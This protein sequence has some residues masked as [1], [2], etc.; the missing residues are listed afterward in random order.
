MQFLSFRPLSWIES[1]KMGAFLSIARGSAEV[2]WL[3]EVRLNFPEG[4]EKSDKNKPV[5]LVGKG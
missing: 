5:V 1:K 4:E 2:P 3:L